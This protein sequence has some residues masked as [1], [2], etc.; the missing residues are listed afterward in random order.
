MSFLYRHEF[1]FGP[2]TW[3]P[4]APCTGAFYYFWS[5]TFPRK[6]TSD[7][8]KDCHCGLARQWPT[9]ALP[10]FMALRKGWWDWPVLQVWMQSLESGS[11][12]SATV[13]AVFPYFHV[14]LNKKTICCT[15]KSNRWHLAITRNCSSDIGKH[16]K[17]I[18][19]FTEGKRPLGRP[20]IDKRIIDGS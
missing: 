14:A 4:T 6:A 3:H 17:F 12:G 20:S 13:S 5:L 9:S 19:L 2:Q 16:I 7:V 10:E 11:I 8:R 15:Q 18:F 1:L